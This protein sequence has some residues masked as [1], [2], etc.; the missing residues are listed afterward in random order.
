MGSD[1]IPVTPD[2]PAVRFLKTL[3]RAGHSPP[4]LPPDVPE[5]H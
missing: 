1:R 2:V 5:F 3:G 4:A